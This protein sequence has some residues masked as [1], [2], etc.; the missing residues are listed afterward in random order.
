M[1]TI[2]AKHSST[3]GALS[4]SIWHNDTLASALVCRRNKKELS[5]PQ[6]LM[7]NKVKISSRK[8]VLILYVRRLGK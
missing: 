3:F 2:K 6:G 8:I 1:T 4:S 7:S 5:N